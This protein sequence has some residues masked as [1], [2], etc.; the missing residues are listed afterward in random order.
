[1]LGVQVN[2][3]KITLTVIDADDLSPLPNVSVFIKNTVQGTATNTQGKVDIPVDSSATYVVRFLGYLTQEFK[4]NDLSETNNTIKMEADVTSLGEIVVSGVAI[5][6][7]K[8]Q[9]VRT[10]QKAV[11]VMGM[12]D[13]KDYLEENITYP[14][15][16]SK[17]RGAVRVEFTI[18]SDGSLSNFEIKKSLGSAF[19]AEAI[20]LIKEGPVWKA[21]TDDKGNAIATSETLRIVFKP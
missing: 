16:E 3:P 12:A 14:E 2:V 10:N 15:N 7:Q 5:E 8:R 9:L 21:A 13:Y 1:M 6:D 11:P 17:K 19:D 20:R 18:N 4:L